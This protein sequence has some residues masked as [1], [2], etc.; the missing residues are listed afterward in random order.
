MLSSTKAY[1]QTLLLFKKFFLIFSLVFLAMTQ[2]AVAAAKEKSFSKFPPEPFRFVREKKPLKLFLSADPAQSEN[3]F[4]RNKKDIHRKMIE[5]RMI[6]VSVSRSNLVGG[7]IAFDV[8]G[9]GIVHAQIESA[10]KISQEFNKL[11]QVSSHF[12]SAFFDEKNNQLFLVISALGFETRM[13]LA[14]DLVVEEKRSEIQFEVVWGELKGM[15]GAIG[16]ENVINEGN[17][18]N[19]DESCEVSILA[20]YQAAKFPLPKIFMGFAFEVVAQKVAEKMRSFI[21]GKK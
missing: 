1:Q 7:L 10:F 3:P 13:I 20:H 2:I 15:T 8:K 21:E 4:W 17:D 14:L 5:E 19:K 6:P 12:K 11:T 18:R 16:F 9:A